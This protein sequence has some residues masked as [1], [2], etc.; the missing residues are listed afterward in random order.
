[1]LLTMLLV[2]E[3]SS[4]MNVFFAVLPYQKWELGHWH[5][6]F[7]NGFLA[8]VPISASVVQRPISYSLVLSLYFIESFVV[9]CLAQLVV[10]AHNLISYFI[11]QLMAACPVCLKLRINEQD[12]VRELLRA[13]VLWKRH[14]ALGKNAWVLPSSWTILNSKLRYMVGSFNRHTSCR[15][16]YQSVVFCGHLEWVIILWSFVG[17]PDWLLLHWFLVRLLE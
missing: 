10:H 13:C 4:F 7:D 9:S 6:V 12:E 2:V 14:H 1:M 8:F 15:R 16:N 3:T 17:H 5:C 11:L